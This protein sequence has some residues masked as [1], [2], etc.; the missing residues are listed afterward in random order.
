MSIVINWRETRLLEDGCGGSIYKVVDTDNSALIDLEM[1]MCTFAPS[2]VSMR[3]HH[4]RI[5][6][7]YFFLEGDAEIRIDETWKTVGS[8]DAVAIP[9]GVSHQIRNKSPTN[10]LRFLSVNSPRWLSEDM[11][12]DPA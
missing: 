9:R 12:I 2:E 6:E 3:H 8:D 11:I 7:I 1:A 10:N 4:N 5:E